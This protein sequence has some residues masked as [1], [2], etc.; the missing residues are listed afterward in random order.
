MTIDSMLQ[1]VTTVSQ[2]RLKIILDLWLLLKLLLDLWLKHFT[3]IA[4]QFL[5]PKFSLSI[6]KTV[7]FHTLSKYRLWYFFNRWILTYWA[8]MNTTRPLTY[9]IFLLDFWL[10]FWL[11]LQLGVQSVL[12]YHPLVTIWHRYALSICS[13]HV[14]PSWNSFLKILPQLIPQNAGIM[15][16]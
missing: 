7:K 8:F 14:V 11:W 15:L 9:R 3:L 2:S 6:N 4:I 16:A 12:A 1:A 5:W 10:S 13:C